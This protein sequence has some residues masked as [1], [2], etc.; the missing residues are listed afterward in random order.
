MSAWSQRP[1]WVKIPH[2]L[3]EEAQS[4][5]EFAV[6]ALIAQHRNWSNPDG[7][8]W[9]SRRRIQEQLGHHGLDPKTVSLATTKL[10][11]SGL[12]RKRH[13]RRSGR[14]R[15]FYT[16]DVQGS[17]EQLDERVLS[18]MAD[19]R[20]TPEDL[21]WL[22]RWQR[23]CGGRRRTS[24][25]AW[26]MVARY[27]TSTRTVKRH[28]QNLIAAGLLQHQPRPGMSSLTMT[29]DHEQ[30]DELLADRLSLP[31]GQV[32]GEPTIW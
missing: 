30:L 26:D 32:W 17:Y 10:E 15:L 18:L 29:L 31:Q 14:A 2:R 9:P 11:K 22:A 8:A 23:A 6:W 27:G 28:R 21:M 25:S 19:R 4:G 24:D 12:L 13:D 7:E 3:L 5:T 20:L 16:L 1:R